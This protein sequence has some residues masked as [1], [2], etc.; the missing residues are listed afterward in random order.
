MDNNTQNPDPMKQ[1]GLLSLSLELRQQIYQYVLP[2]PGIRDT[3]SL[4][5]RGAQDWKF[6]LVGEDKSTIL[7][8]SK[9]IS[10]EALNVLYGANTFK[11]ALHGDPNAQ[12]SKIAPQNR[13][14][15]R[16]FQLILRPVDI[17]Y[18]KNPTRLDSQIWDPML[19]NLLE[20]CIAAQEPPQAQ[21]WY[22]SQT[23][24]Q[25]MLR[26][27][28]WVAAVFLYL[29]F[30]VPEHLV[31]QMDVGNQEEAIKLVHRYITH[32]IRNVETRDGNFWFKRGMYAQMSRHWSEDYLAHSRGI[33]RCFPQP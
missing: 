3:N 12:L 11:V 16:R 23:F 25:D 4:N 21:G 18:G 28:W 24:K 19:A 2:E 10:S 14:R 1:T 32:G 27:R 5:W 31:F 20:L 26:W 17:T 7:R 30:R 8:V 15:V 29:D 13:K 6:T 9:Q 33:A 22:I